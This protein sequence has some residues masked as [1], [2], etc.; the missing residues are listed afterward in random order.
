MEPELEARFCELYQRYY[1]YIF[2][3]T[4]LL[5]RAESAARDL[6]DE[7]FYKV[8]CE[9]ERGNRKVLDI[10]YLARMATNLCLDELRRQSARKMIELQDELL[11]LDHT[12]ETEAGLERG[13]SLRRLFERL[14][15]KLRAIAVYRLVDGYSLEEMVALCGL[16]KR[17]LQRR[18]RRILAILQA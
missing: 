17:T 13:I 18:L 8:V 7:V 6:T 10:R 12:A 14:P 2:K 1:F 15:P 4:L 11:Y 16:P 9:L 3:R 5:V